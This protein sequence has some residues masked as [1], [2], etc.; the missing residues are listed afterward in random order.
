[1]PFRD[2]G[3]MRK[4][5]R[6]KESKLVLW[7]EA[8][9]GGTHGFPDAVVIDDGRVIFVEL[10]VGAL[11]EAG[12]VEFQMAN[13]QRIVLA[14]IAKAGG[15]AIVF[16]GEVGGGRVWI[17]FGGQISPK[18]GGREVTRMAD[19]IPHVIAPRLVWEES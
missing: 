3:D 14:D 7:V 15:E 8:K 6:R 4:W 1:M 12:L 10:K 2:E 11:N 13:S 16:V 18:I 9:R 17:G 19:R 5:L